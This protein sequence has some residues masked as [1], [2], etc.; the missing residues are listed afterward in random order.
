MNSSKFSI[1]VCN[2]AIFRTSRTGRCRCTKVN[3][4]AVLTR[5]AAVMPQTKVRP[6]LIEQFESIK[7][8]INDNNI[9]IYF[10]SYFFVLLCSPLP[11]RLPCLYVHGIRVMVVTG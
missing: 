6:V 2:S 11:T 7:E 10:S 9:G 3:G 4:C 1:Y 5:A 8:I